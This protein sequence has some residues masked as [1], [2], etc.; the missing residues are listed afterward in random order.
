MRRA[1]RPRGRPEVE[2]PYRRTPL[3]AAPKPRLGTIIACLATT[4]AGPFIG[5][6]VLGQVSEAGLLLGLGLSL[7]P[8]AGLALVVRQYH[9]RLRRLPPA[10]TAEWMQGKL[11]PAAGGPA[12]TAPWRYAR[13]KDW[14][15]L[16]G[17][18]LL[19]S[20]HVLLA[21]PG[22][23]QAMERLW[24][25]GEIGEF[26][27]EWAALGEWSVCDESDGPDTYRV[28]LRAGGRL[29]LR[30]FRGAAASE[31]DLLDAVRSIGA[32]PVRMLAEVADD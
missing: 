23:A 3:P 22:V 16:R 6:A 20:R 1:V 30:R 8:L 31:V 7:L 13:G 29:H 12:V 24:M 14:I 10:L 28:S 19:V 32:L 26:F 15:E 5:F 11:V 4:L 18:G 21:L 2:H 9:R 17:D 25:A 27:I